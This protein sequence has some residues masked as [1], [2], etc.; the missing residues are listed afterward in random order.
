MILYI[1]HL[2]IP[3]DAL[4]TFEPKAEGTLENLIKLSAEGARDENP[5][6]LRQKDRGII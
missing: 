4:G 5:E 3:V 6:S 2:N 1:Q